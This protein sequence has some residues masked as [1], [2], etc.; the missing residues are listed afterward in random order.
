MVGR[1][2]YLWNSGI[3]VWRVSSILRALERYAPDIA[4][5]RPQGARR[6]PR[7][8]WR[9]PATVLRR[10]PRSPIDRAVLE[11]S[12]EVLVL[13]ATFAWSDVGNWDTLGALLRTDARGNGAIGRI[14]GLDAA[15]CVA[16]NRKGLTVFLGL[17]DVVAARSGN[18]VLV[19]HRAAAQKVRE[20]VRQLRG[21]LAAYR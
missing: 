1:R 17:R 19:C 10:V 7:G 12:R 21:S 14:L 16:V 9:V 11:R 18:V 6:A 5:P 3:F 20:V 8:A 2:R 15:R 13:R 4:A